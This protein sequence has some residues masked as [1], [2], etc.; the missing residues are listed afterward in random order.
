LSLNVKPHTKPNPEPSPNA[1]LYTPSRVP[2]L[3]GYDVDSIAAP[4]EKKRA[5]PIP[6]T[7]LSARIA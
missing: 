1:A 3:S 6:A 4:V 2:T 7:N 5:A